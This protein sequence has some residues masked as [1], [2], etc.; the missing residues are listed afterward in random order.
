MGKS[1]ERSAKVDSDGTGL[2]A[3]LCPCLGLGYRFSA[4]QV[5]AFAG[6]W[7]RWS[8]PH[9]DGPETCTV[10]TTEANDLVRP[11]H[12]RMPVILPAEFY[13]DWL[14][15]KATARSGCRPCCGRTP[16]WPSWRLR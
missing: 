7:E 14:D 1:R 6:L 11:S 3:S 2:L 9:G 5:R 13:G 10:L 8:G 4:N 12:E 15:P 16:P